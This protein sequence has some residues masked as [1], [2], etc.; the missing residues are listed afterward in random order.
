MHR[1]SLTVAGSSTLFAAASVILAQIQT[2]S[3]DAP[4]FNEVDSSASFTAL[5]MTRILSQPLGWPIS[6]AIC[7]F[8]HSVS[9]PMIPK[10]LRVPSEHKRLNRAIPSN[11]QGGKMDTVNAVNWTQ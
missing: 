7:Y 9:N 6:E 11:Y 4:Y 10:Y 3:I 8:Q 1:R 2:A 5:K